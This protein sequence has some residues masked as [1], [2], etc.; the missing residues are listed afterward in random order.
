MIIKFSYR[1]KFRTFLN[2]FIFFYGDKKFRKR[3]QLYP[4][5]LI[6]NLLKSDNFLHF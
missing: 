5:I 1:Q 3:D 4:I 2:F 6:G